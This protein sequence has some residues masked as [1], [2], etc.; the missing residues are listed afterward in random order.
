VFCCY[1]GNDNLH[2]L[3]RSKPMKLRIDLTDWADNSSFA[4]YSNF[5]VAE[6]GLKYKLVSVGVFSGDA[7]KEVF[8]YKACLT[9]KLSIV[10]TDKHLSFPATPVEV[11]WNHRSTYC[12]GY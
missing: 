9:F 8:L 4:E 6:S 10:I 2:R 7:G 5:V 12:V 1:V 11:R 3:T